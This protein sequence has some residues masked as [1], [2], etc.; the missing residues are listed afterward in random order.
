MNNYTE[1]ALDLISQ[2]S[3]L[4][5]QSQYEKALEKFSEAQKDSPKYIECYINL[6][7]AYSCLE[8]YEDAIDASKRL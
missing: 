4:M 8:K 3:T 1:N 7:N 2:G 5:A 6:G